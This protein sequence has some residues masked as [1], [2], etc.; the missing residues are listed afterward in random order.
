MVPVSGECAN[1]QLPSIGQDLVPDKTAFILARYVSH[2]CPH[3]A[4]DRAHASEIYSIAVQ[5]LDS[6]SLG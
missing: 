2:P 6:S 1:A 4:H 5:K 3:A